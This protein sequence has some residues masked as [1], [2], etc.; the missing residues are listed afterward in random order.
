MRRPGS[1]QESLPD[2]SPLSPP[3]N[4]RLALSDSSGGSLAP[5]HASA[6]LIES[7]SAS[8]LFAGGDSGERSR[9]KPWPEPGRR[10]SPP[11]PAGNV[12]IGAQGTGVLA[13]DTHRG[14][15][16]DDALGPGLVTVPAEHVADGIDRADVPELTLT[17]L[18]GPTTWGRPVVALV[19]LGCGAVQIAAPT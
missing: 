11:V 9:T 8:R 19:L 3:A 12:L 16:S 13:T 6:P 4:R 18:N 2:R 15:G 14:E 10:R 7:D 17:Q 1:G 5:Q